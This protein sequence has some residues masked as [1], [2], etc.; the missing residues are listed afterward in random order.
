MAAVQMPGACLYC[1]VCIAMGHFA[2]QGTP[3]N[4]TRACCPCR[5][6]LFLQSQDFQR[7]TELMINSLYSSSQHAAQQ[8]EAVDSHLE[9][10]LLT[11]EGLD[12]SLGTVATAQSQ[13]LQ[14]AE[15]NLKSIG[16]LQNDSQALHTQLEQ[17]LQN[18]VSQAGCS[19]R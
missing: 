6:C 12:K 2:L 14:L 11:M 5:M 13:Q 15:Q 8:L 3:S 9:Q 18:E 7:H 1:D 10:S 17:A 16:Q 4:L 19:L